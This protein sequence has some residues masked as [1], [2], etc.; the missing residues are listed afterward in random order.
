MKD[1]ILL[2]LAELTIPIIGGVV[3]AFIGM[4]IAHLLGIM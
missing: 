1:K 2:T 4:A 3:G